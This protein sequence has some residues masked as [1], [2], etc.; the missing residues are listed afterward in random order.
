MVAS[1]FNEFIVSRLL[2]GARAAFDSAGVPDSLLIVSRVPG[3]FEIPLA[4]RLLI[5]RNSVDAVVALGC[6]IRGE[7]PHFDYVASAAASGCARVALDTGKPVIFGLLATD[8][9]EQAMQRAGPGPANKGH[10]AAIAAIEMAEEIR[11]IL[12]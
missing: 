7:T 2:L 9:V 5:Q 1:R 8:T 4:C 12:Q 11:R 3:A 10:Q 6:V